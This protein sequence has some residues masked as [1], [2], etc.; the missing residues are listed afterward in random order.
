MVEGW[1]NYLDALYREQSKLYNDI[2][3]A[4]ELGLS[5][6][7]IRRNLIQKANLGSAEVNM[8]MRGMF[9]PGMASKEVLQEVRMQVNQEQRARLTKTVPIA[10]LNRLSADRRGQPLA[11]RVFEREQVEQARPQPAE[12]PKAEPLPL[13]GV[14]DEPVQP[15]PQPAPQAQPATPA[16]TPSPELLGSNPFEQLRNMQ[17]SERLRQDR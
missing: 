12:T 6:V 5:D 8:I 16:P 7:Q 17:L 10:Q 14:P 11:P 9:N 1:E 15:T 13:F 3:A 4:R 2:Q